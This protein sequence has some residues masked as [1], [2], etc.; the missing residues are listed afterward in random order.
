MLETLARVLVK[1]E[2]E[3]VVTNHR[4]VCRNGERNHID[5]M[6]CQRCNRG[7][8]QL[9]KCHYSQQLKQDT[10]QCLL[11]LPEGDQQIYSHQLS[12]LTYR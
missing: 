6:K 10:K 12:K 1:E 2:L 11:H 4:Q 3:E 5:K 8:L 9:R 7:E